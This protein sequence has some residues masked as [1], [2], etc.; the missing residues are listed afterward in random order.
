M[1]A[2]SHSYQ[3]QQQMKKIVKIARLELS[4]MFYSPIAWLVLIIFLMQTS[5]VYTELLYG[6]ETMQQLERPLSVLTK[7]L[8][9]GEKG[10]LAIVQQYLYLYI[11]LLTMGLMSRETSSGSIKLLY[12]SPVT[13][14][15]IVLGKYLSMVVYN[16]LLTLILLSFIIAG[17]ISVEALDIKFVLGGILGIYLLM[18]AY[19][20]IGLFMSSLTSYQV[21]AAI[22]TLAVLA[23]L[24]FVGGIGQ[25]YDVVR[26]ITYW[27]S[28]KGRADN[29]VN[30]LISSKDIVYFLLVI[31][32]FLML[33]IIKLNNQR[34]TRTLRA[35]IGS[36]GLL[37]TMVIVV[38]YITSLPTINGYYD[39]TR[40]KDRTLTEASQAIVEQLDKPISITSYVNLVH[41][42][43]SH[44]TL[45]NRIKDLKQFEKYRRFLPDMKMDY[46]YYYD[47]VRYNID[48][49]KTLIEKAQQA[50]K[51]HRMDFDRLLPPSEIKGMVDLVSEDNRFVRFIEYNGKTV[52]LRMFDDIFVY[53]KEKEISSTLKRLIQGP[54][55]VGVLTGNGERNTYQTSDAAYK[56]ITKGLNVR[57]SL[58]NSGFDVIDLD[59]QHTKEIPLDL[60]V[61]ILADPKHAYTEEQS[62]KIARYIEAGGNLLI[63]GEPGRQLVLNPII[64]KLGVSFLEGELLQES[65]NFELDLVQ[66]KFTKDAAAYGFS[67]YDKA[68]AILPKATALS[69]TSTGDYDMTPILVTDKQSTW[70]KLG[71]FDLSTDKIVFDSISESRIEVPVALALTKK[72]ADKEQKI[73]IVGDAD[74]MSNG[75]LNR[76]APR[77]VN[78]SFAIRMFKWFSDG[79]YP[80]GIVRPKSIDTRVLLSRKGIIWLKFV[81]LGLVPVLIGGWGTMILI[82]RHRN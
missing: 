25:T 6:R 40:F 30:G 41:Y 9:A 18:C 43:A 38:G 54:V 34:K 23:A 33:S 58:I 68:V 24:N 13:I 50:A 70:N 81:F 55:T 35:K 16:L 65:E 51:A 36:Y 4:I 64:E 32:L 57:G 82:R 22:S 20:A 21:V 44:G 49:T 10:I 52:P 74:F 67:F 37:V 14:K 15:Q 17:V 26:D 45:K 77:N 19:A 61:L 80:V 47:T 8:F 53:P 46:V 1:T 29:L 73:M 75:E 3:K 60:G 42:T 59:L 7:I 56:I 72:I 12:S 76:R 28:I 48:T 11:P 69:Y 62:Q 63:A 27:L 66:G 71:T 39:T 31:G 78:A 2:Y 5:L 79:E